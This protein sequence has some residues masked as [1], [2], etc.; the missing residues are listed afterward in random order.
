MVSR[1]WEEWVVG[2]WLVEGSWLRRV[3]KFGGLKRHN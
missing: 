3:G 2:G 1:D